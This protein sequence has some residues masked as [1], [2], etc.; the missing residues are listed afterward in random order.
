MHRVINL[1]LV[2]VFLCE[3]Y[4]IHPSHFI[5]RDEIFEMTTENVTQNDLIESAS[6]FNSSDEY[7]YDYKAYPN[8]TESTENGTTAANDIRAINYQDYEYDVNGHETPFKDDDKNVTVWERE[9]IPLSD[10]LFY[11]ELL[12][13]PS[14][15]REVVAIELKKHECG[16]DEVNTEQKGN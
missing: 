15:P 11:N 9:C 3:S 13:D 6:K 4:R 1:T 8:D 2:F 16:F 14:S 7:V 5:S 10:C 12:N